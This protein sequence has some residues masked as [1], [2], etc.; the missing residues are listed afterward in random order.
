MDAGDDAE[1]MWCL[2][3]YR[4]H[5]RHRLPRRETFVVK[6]AA[7]DLNSLI[8]RLIEVEGTRAR[9]PGRWMRWDRASASCGSLSWPLP[10]D[11]NKPVGSGAGAGLLAGHWL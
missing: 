11:E 9:S 1:Q 5:G 8:D 2:V 3:A 10:V 4:D 7:G 6:C